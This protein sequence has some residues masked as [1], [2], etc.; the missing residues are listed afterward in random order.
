[1][2]I[3]FS[4][5]ASQSPSG[6][7]P[8]TGSYSFDSTTLL[9]WPSST[10]GY[11]LYTGGFANFD[12][13][14][15]TSPILSLSNFNINN[16]GATNQIYVSTNGYITL[17]EGGGDLANSPTILAVGGATIA[18]NPSDLWLQ[19]GRALSDGDTQNIYYQSGSLG[20][21]KYYINFIVYSAF[22]T[23]RGQPSSYLLNLYIDNN[24]QWV[25]TRIKSNTAGG[26]TG[27]YNATSVAQPA[28]TSSRVWVGDLAGQNWNYLGTGRVIP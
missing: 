12:E 27:P 19:P 10:T 13:S 4:F 9:S 26:T 2:F 17:G 6:P 5:F 20:D 11:T 16:Q 14:Y 3:P 23:N 25:E 8:L 22:F 1:M 18:G 24:Y 7:P 21:N 15:T 28:S